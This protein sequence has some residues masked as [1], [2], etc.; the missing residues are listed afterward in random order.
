MRLGNSF[1]R[2]DGENVGFE[3]PISSQPLIT[4]GSGALPLSLPPPQS[5]TLS[6]FSDIF[7]I[8]TSGL[9]ATYTAGLP[10]SFPDPTTTT[11]A[12]NRSSDT[13][14]TPSNTITVV[15]SS[16]TTTVSSSLIPTA[17]AAGNESTATIGGAVGGA[18]G[19]ILIAVVVV[20]WIRRKRGEHFQVVLKVY[21]TGWLATGS[22]RRQRPNFKVTALPITTTGPEHVTEKTRERRKQVDF[23][24]PIVDD[25]RVD[26]ELLARLDMIME[27]VA[28]SQEVDSPEDNQRASA[29]G[30][31][32][33]V[34]AKLDIIM[35][36]VARLEAPPDY[37][38]NRS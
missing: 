28:R 11:E 9:P 5:D 12:G 16:P 14:T 35:E 27:R 22:D 20:V 21:T 8:L 29:R 24:G 32:S 13:I 6:E 38:P 10:L 25:Q 23:P 7:T 17:A 30:T 31:D 37:T 18:I 1:E 19:V 3:F 34:L 15:S 26:S 33:E 2:R 36:R 4:P